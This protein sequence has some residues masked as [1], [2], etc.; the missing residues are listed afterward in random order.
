MTYCEPVEPVS[1]KIC[2]ARHALMETGL[3]GLQRRA[4]EFVLKYM[5]TVF[6]YTVLLTG[7]ADRS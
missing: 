6:I 2:Q 3:S 1:I 4:G 7:Q 5:Y